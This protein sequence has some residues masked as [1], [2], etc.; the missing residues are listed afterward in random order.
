ARGNGGFA[1]HLA[2]PTVATVATVAVGWDSRRTDRRHVLAIVAR[3]PDRRHVLAVVARRDVADAPLAR[4]VVPAVAR[5][6]A[7][8]A[9]R[10]V[11][12]VP[13]ARA[14][15]PAS[16]VPI[17]TLGGR[18]GVDLTIVTFEFAELRRARA[19]HDDRGQRDPD[20]PGS[21]SHRITSVM[22]VRTL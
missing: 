14:V 6:A 8:R 22:L 20:P 13:L 15:V 12:D 10:G 16:R 11:A 5:A 2:R 18:R 7:A 19:R 1:G 4:A 21:H 17:A 3:A 9:R